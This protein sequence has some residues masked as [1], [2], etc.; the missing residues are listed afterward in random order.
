MYMP[1]NTTLI[2]ATLLTLACAHCTKSEQ[3][4]LRQ[5]T[6]AEVDQL[7]SPAY[8]SQAKLET[9][10][11]IERRDAYGTH[12]YN[13]TLLLD[14]E[15]VSQLRI[16]QS[17]PFEMTFCDTAAAITLGDGKPI[18]IVLSNKRQNVLEFREVSVVALN[19]F[20]YLR[21]QYDFFLESS[22]GDTAHIIAKLQ[23]AQKDAGRTRISIEKRRGFISDIMFY[24]PSGDMGRHVAYRKP[25]R[26][27]EGVLPTEI[28]IDFPFQATIVKEHY[29][30]LDVLA[31]ES[32]KQ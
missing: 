8:F 4:A 13:G 6:Q 20:R 9:P 2:G 12:S 23:T 11:V 14:R 19:P 17:T 1:G 26:S 27:S 18:N 25:V 30:L 16:N 28:F 22:P 7:L 32:G 24:A 31:K 15:N 10:L 5:V 3:E 21:Q 29:I